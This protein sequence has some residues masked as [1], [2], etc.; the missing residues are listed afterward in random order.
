MICSFEIHYYNCNYYGLFTVHSI[1]V[2]IHCNKYIYDL[3][4]VFVK[5]YCAAK[6]TIICFF[7]L[8][9]LICDTHSLF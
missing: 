6:M 1:P 7:K 5:I 2:E 3:F 4:N 8:M 9:L